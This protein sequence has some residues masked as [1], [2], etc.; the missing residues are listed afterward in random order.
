MFQDYNPLREIQD[1]EYKVTDVKFKIITLVSR[2]HCVIG[3]VF[4]VLNPDNAAEFD[5][6]FIERIKN[7]LSL[8]VEKDLVRQLEEEIA[9]KHT[10]RNGHLG[11]QYE[12][13]LK[14]MYKAN[15]DNGSDEEG[16]VVD[17][18][19]YQARSP[20]KRGRTNNFDDEGKLLT[21][22]GAVNQPGESRQTT[23]LK[24][25]RSIRNPDF[26]RQSLLSARQSTVLTDQNP[27]K[28]SALLSAR[29]A[30]VRS[31]T[32]DAASAKNQQELRAAQ[33]ATQSV[34][35]HVHDEL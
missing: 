17:L 8:M 6:Y 20:P 4:H 32:L 26:I 12:E 7:C 24:Q 35:K 30:P 18:G 31:S 13:K 5:P 29:R 16:D 10:L 28:S 25:Q 34:A 11:R 15:E 22:R 23:A 19:N 2:G 9:L 3:A 14:D 21:S 1:H 33:E 27:G